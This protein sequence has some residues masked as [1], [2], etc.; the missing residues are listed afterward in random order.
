MRYGRD[1]RGASLTVDRDGYRETVPVAPDGRNT[2]RIRGLLGLDLDV[3]E[4][5]G[6][7]AAFLESPLAFPVSGRSHA[8]T[9]IGPS[10]VDNSTSGAP[11][12]ENTRS[13]SPVTSN[14]STPI[15]HQVNGDARAATSAT[16]SNLAMLPMSPPHAGAAPRIPNPGV[17]LRTLGLDEAH[18][19][20]VPSG[21]RPCQRR[22]GSRGRDASGR[23][24][25]GWTS[26]FRPTSG[27]VALPRSIG[28]PPVR[29]NARSTRASSMVSL[30]SYAAARMITPPLSAVK[31]RRSS[32]K[33]RSR[34]I[35]VQW[36][37]RA[38]V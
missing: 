10:K 35:S 7:G 9:S 38:S 29:Q 30:R 16:V 20:D 36:S 15:T 18:A 23:D 37:R 33:S 4:G 1:E 32:K 27:A 22:V 26:I 2:N 17:H 13:S 31:N 19:A 6:V 14:P 21:A 28:Q 8:S 11:L 34:L 12:T 25:S 5:V 24:Q 3:L